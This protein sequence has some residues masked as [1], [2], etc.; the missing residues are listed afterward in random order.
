MNNAGEAHSNRNFY[1]PR[2]FVVL[3]GE[4]KMLHIQ[5]GMF[6]YDNNRG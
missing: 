2:N 6:D 1:G 3:Y 4:L 5:N